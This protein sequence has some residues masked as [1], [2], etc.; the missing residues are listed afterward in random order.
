MNI[1]AN[2]AVGHV[3]IFENGTKYYLA[4]YCLNHQTRWSVR[5]FRTASD[6]D[7]YAGRVVTRYERLIAKKETK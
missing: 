1:L 4:R 5:K 7:I 6:A 3:R 2:H